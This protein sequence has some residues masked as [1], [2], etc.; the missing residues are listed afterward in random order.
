MSAKRPVGLTKDAGWQVGVSRTVPADL[1]TVWT[2]LVSPE[3]LAAWLGAGAAP[4]PEVGAPYTTA[5]GTTGEMR[6]WRRHDRLRATRLA[7]RH[8]HETTI[9]VTVSTTPTGTRIGL[10][11]ERMASE[12]E[13]SRMRDHWKHV[14]DRLAS[15]L[16]DG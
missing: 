4:D 3:G 15:A 7:P 1:E 14:A 5:D 10:H 13:R 12:G 8:D 6:S 2:H 9:Q 16:G 11:Q